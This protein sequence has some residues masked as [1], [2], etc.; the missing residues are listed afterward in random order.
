MPSSTELSSDLIDKAESKTTIEPI[1]EVEKV[2]MGT[3]K[4]TNIGKA[5][6]GDTRKELVSFLRDNQSVFAWTA[7]DMPGIP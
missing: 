5:V 1:D 7:A 4:F 3:E 6:Q 2:E